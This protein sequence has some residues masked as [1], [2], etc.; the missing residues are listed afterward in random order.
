MVK[1]VTLIP[2]LRKHRHRASLTMNSTSNWKTKWAICTACGRRLT[3]G[4]CRVVG[5]HYSIP[6][7]SEV[8]VDITMLPSKSNE[9]RCNVRANENSYLRLIKNI[10]LNEMYGHNQYWHRYPKWTALHN[11]PSVV[12]RYIQC[13]IRRLRPTKPNG[14]DKSQ[15]YAVGSHK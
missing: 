5:T 14:N 13:R 8:V 9:N 12:V 6:L 2:T 15:F 11:W 3:R 4:K 7:L 10:V 1:P